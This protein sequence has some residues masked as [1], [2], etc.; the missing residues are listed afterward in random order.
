MA[1]SRAW[2]CSRLIAHFIQSDGEIEPGFR[3]VGIVLQCLAVFCRRLR[4]VP[5]Q[6]KLVRAAPGC[7]GNAFFHA[8]L[9]RVAEDLEFFLGLLG[10]LQCL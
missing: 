4:R 7:L 2:R 10:P 9:L 1:F 5:L 6:Q 3:I 8:P